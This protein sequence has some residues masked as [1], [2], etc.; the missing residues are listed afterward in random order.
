VVSVSL[1]RKD[2]ERER[3][4]EIEEKGVAPDREMKGMMRSLGKM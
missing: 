1:E 4:R 2:E 3:E